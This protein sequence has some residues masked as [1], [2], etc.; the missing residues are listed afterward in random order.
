MDDE[1]DDEDKSEQEEKEEGVTD[2]SDEDLK[3]ANNTDLPFPLASAKR[4]SEF[5]L[6][7]RS[8]PESDALIDD[9]KCALH[10]DILL[11]GHLYLSQH[12][13]CF[14]A[15]IFGWVTHLVVAYDE[16]I[17]MEKRNTAMIIPNG[18]QI[19][20]AKAKHVFASLMSRD[21]TYD[22]MYRLWQMHHN[23][24]TVLRALQT[25]DDMTQD[26]P[27][28]LDDD[29]TA[30]WWSGLEDATEDKAENPSPCT[31]ADHYPVTMLDRVYP[32]T[33]KSMSYLLFH[34]DFLV[35]ALKAEGE[36]FEFSAWQDHMRESK[37]TTRQARAACIRRDERLDRPE[38]GHATLRTTL[39]I[40]N[41][42]MLCL[43]T[44]ITNVSANDGPRVRLTITLDVDLAAPD[45]VQQAAIASQK[46]IA[47]RVDALLRTQR[48]Q[49]YLE[50]QQQSR[51]Q[52]SLE[53]KHDRRP[54]YTL[55][56]IAAV[57]THLLVAYRM[58]NVSIRIANFQQQHS[59][60][61]TAATVDD[62]L[63]ALNTQITAITAQMD[64]IQFEIAD[65][66]QQLRHFAV[67]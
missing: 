53:S 60:Q 51:K 49:R 36:A 33:V 67:Q 34:P 64:R 44:C 10:R 45:V 8:V 43:L 38:D 37:Y 1:Y 14:H 66:E 4:N 65:Q 54:F 16:I 11:Q 32:G 46:R 57:L 7:F 30:S 3:K 21:V 22:Q 24:V 40:E 23:A 47:A 58:G 31:C 15:N 12:H 9:Y 5:H 59:R 41:A 42:C 18:I 52:A 28:E 19:S 20:T 2:S 13:V 26:G 61:Q 29:D 62:H 27:V 39:T 55:C 17:S 56:L 48:A 6:L 50:Q 25:P 63:A 35:R